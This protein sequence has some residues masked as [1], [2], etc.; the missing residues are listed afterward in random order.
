MSEPLGYLQPASFWTPNHLNT[1]AWLEHAPFAFGL[2]QMLRPRVIVELG[3]HHGFSYLCFCQAVQGCRLSTR[4]YAVDT[5]KGDDHAGFYGDEV[6]N[7]LSALHSQHYTGFSS[8]L[9]MP[10]EEALPYFADG[11]I[12]LLHIDGR[13]GYDDVV[14]DFSQW[15]AKLSDR[16]VVLFH[17]TNVRQSE[18]GVWKFWQELAVK[19][20]RQW[21]GRARPRHKFTC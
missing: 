12:D 13:H 1:S 20:P 15:Q 11:E 4:C 18:F 16:A 17:D 8:L 7:E 14:Q 5:W 19:Y 2:V 10:F 21:A 9:R 3:T 6:F